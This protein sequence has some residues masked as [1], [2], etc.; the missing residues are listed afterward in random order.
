MATTPIPTLIHT[1]A[2]F[3]DV[4][5]TLWPLKSQVWEVCHTCATY[6]VSKII[7]EHV[8]FTHREPRSSS[9]YINWEK[10]RSILSMI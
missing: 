5:I 8:Q 6:D 10:I 7:T 1:L 4:D 9:Q 2:L 3:A